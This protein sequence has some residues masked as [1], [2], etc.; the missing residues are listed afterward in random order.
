M[1]AMFW[2]QW[3]VAAAN[4]AGYPYPVRDSNPVSGREKTA[5]YP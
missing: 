3:E 5:A 1:A 2:V 4:A